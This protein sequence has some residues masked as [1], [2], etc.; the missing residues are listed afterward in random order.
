MNLYFFIFVVTM[1]HLLVEK[2]KRKLI[3]GQPSSNDQTLSFILLWFLIYCRCLSP[4]KSTCTCFANFFSINEI[5]AKDAL[6]NN[7]TMLLRFLIFSIAFL[8]LFS[9]EDSNN[10]QC[11]TYKMLLKLFCYEL[12]YIYIYMRIYVYIIGVIRSL[13]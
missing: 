4:V 1:S 2:S 3:P 5:L 8:V 9:W 11:W 7:D 10:I 12:I 13:W 6:K